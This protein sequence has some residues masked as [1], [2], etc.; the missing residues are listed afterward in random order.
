MTGS[1]AKFVPLTTTTT[2]F[3]FLHV[4]SLFTIILFWTLTCI[5]LYIVHDYYMINDL[6]IPGFE[7][8]ISL[9][10][11]ERKSLA[12]DTLYLFYMLM[13]ICYELTRT[14]CSYQG[15]YSSDS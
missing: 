9:C 2:H 5:I 10:F 13:M 11:S 15:T 6:L 3:L 14:F 4:L 1:A 12:T 8:H 7:Y